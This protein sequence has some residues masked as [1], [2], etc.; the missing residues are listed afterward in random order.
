VIR[1]AL[2]LTTDHIRKSTKIR[3]TTFLA[4]WHTVRPSLPFCLFDIAKLICVLTY[5]ALAIVHI[6]Y[7]SHTIWIFDHR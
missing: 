4:L 7:S 2:H 3:G 1:Y 6:D 5:L